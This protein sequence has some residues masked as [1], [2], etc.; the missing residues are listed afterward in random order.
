V[1]QAPVSHP[2]PAAQPPIL[3]LTGSIGSG[4]TL[5]T[6]QLQNLGAVVI[7]ADELAREAVAPGTPGLEEIIRQFGPEVLAGD[8]SLDRQKMAAIVFSDPGRRR[9]LEAIIHPR[10]RQQELA[11]I[12][13]SGAAPLVV[14]EIP[15]LFE[16]GAEELCDNVCV[17]TTPDSERRRR[18]R[19]D[20]AMSDEEISR[21]LS[22]QMPDDEKVRRADYVIDNSG[23]PE[24]TRDQVERLYR[25]L[26]RV[27]S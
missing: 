26:A 9:A 15:L 3:G 21:R 10:V 2:L 8:G 20:R 19:R 24:Q 22:A 27:P 11:L 18:L 7:R 6:T 17:V 1:D 14:L 23:T 25:R 13:Q 5:V 12:A 16:T 4:K